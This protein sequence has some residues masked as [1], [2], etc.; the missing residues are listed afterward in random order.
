VVALGRSSPVPAPVPTAPRR[1]VAPRPD[2]PAPPSEVGALEDVEEKLGSEVVG[3]LVVVGTTVGVLGE[4]GVEGMLITGGVGVA[5]ETTGVLGGVLVWVMCEHRPSHPPLPAPPWAD[6]SGVPLLP[7]DCGLWASPGVDPG[8]PVLGV[9]VV[10]GWTTCGCGGV[11]VGGSTGG[12]LAWCRWVTVEG[13]V[14]AVCG[15]CVCCGCC[16]PPT[17]TEPPRP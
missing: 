16:W 3:M 15:C 10:L 11:L 6:G 7:V 4:D 8:I 9:G 13:P 2:R 5:W 14:G 1:A 12:T 17:G